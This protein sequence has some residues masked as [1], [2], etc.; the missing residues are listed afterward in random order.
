M[1]KATLAALTAIIGAAIGAGATV[2]ASRY[3]WLGKR[4]ESESV[5]LGRVLERLDKVEAKEAECQSEVFNLRTEQ[6][7]LELMVDILID[8]CPDADGDVTKVRQRMI[9]RRRKQQAD[10]LH[11]TRER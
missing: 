4:V 2:L 8:R 3:G 11:V 7:T 1:D 9:E 5:I 6:Q 10:D